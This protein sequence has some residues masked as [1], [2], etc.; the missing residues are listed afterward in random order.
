MK[1]LDI[2]NQDKNLSKNIIKDLKKIIDKCDFINGQKVNEF[3]KKF[4]SYCKSKYAI[5]CANGT[6]AIFL[7]LKSL[8]LKKGSEVILPAMTYC[9]TAFSVINAGLKPVL[10]DIYPDSPVVSYENVKKKINSKTKVILI[11]H[12]YGQSCDIKKFN[13]LKKSHNLYIIEDASQAHGAYDING[14]NVG[15]YSD[16][17]CFS[18][19]PGKNLGA[20]GDAG[21][22]TTN[23]KSFFNHIKKLGN[24]GS[25]KK[26][27]H[28][29]VGVNSRLDTLQASILIHKL[30][31]LDKNNKKRKSIAKYYDKNIINNK[32]SKIN[33][34]QGCVFHQYVIIVNDINNFIE[35]LKIYKI[36]FGRHYP[37]ALHQLTSLKK[38]FRNEKYPHSERLAKYGISLPIDPSLTKN[39]LEKIVKT[40]NKF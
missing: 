22:I 2:K 20:Y 12:L 26:Y 4:A 37:F 39:N 27:Y 11:V 31:N 3:E 21:V 30:K 10:A 40:I 9:S 28:D 15:S 32:V 23:K 14:I 7:A 8:N 25:N 36:P 29:L 1:F 18:L 34:S 35:Y 6:D 5:G 19:Y 16:I 33:Y 17:S 38:K 24:L 13:L